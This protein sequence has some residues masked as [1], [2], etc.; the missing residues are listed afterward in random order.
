VPIP[1]PPLPEDL[2][3]PD[4]LVSE[5]SVPPPLPAVVIDQ[6]LQAARHFPLQDQFDQGIHIY[7]YAEGGVYMVYCAPGRITSLLFEPGEGVIQYAGGDPSV[8]KVTEVAS[9]ER[10]AA[11]PV[12]LVKPKLPN[13][14]SNLV[15]TTTKRLYLI[16]LRSFKHSHM[17]AVSWRYPQDDFVRQ[18]QALAERQQAQQDTISTGV[19][20]DHLDF[21][22]DIRVVKGDTPVWLPERVFTDGRRTFIEFPDAVALTDVPALF[23]RTGKDTHLVNY[24]QEG[25]YFVVDRPVEVGE[26]RLGSHKKHV[27]VRVQKVGPSAVRDVSHSRAEGAA[28]W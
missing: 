25:R 6:A 28:S 2:A 23:L 21:G 11:R 18:G 13:L 24:R 19:Q 17:V 3:D 1:P 8:W 26:L 22:Y 14:R 16:E 27:V 10:E 20:L 7:P 12:L 5:P 4:E 9:G 15:V